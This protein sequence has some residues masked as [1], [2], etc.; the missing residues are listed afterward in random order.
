MV[1]VELF[2]GLTVGLGICVWQHYRWRK[3][4]KDLINSFSSQD[5]RSISLPPIYLVR[6][7]IEHLEQERK[8]VTQ[9]R[10]IWQRLIDRAPIG[11]L[12]VDEENQLL[13][14]NQQARI[15]L[16]LDRWRWG[17]VRLL[18]E[19]VR[20]Y[21]LDRLI[22]RTRKSQ[23][24]QE[25]EWIFY[26]TRHASAREPN[27]ASS[28][29]A[30]ASLKTVNAIALCGHSF[31]LPDRQV[32]VFLI[33]RQPIVD[34][35]HSRDRAIS[36]LA[37]E[38]KTPL[39]SISLVAENLLNR[40]QNPERGWVEQML[41]ETN[42]LITLVKEWLDLTQLEADPTKVL[43]YEEILLQEL[44]SS[45][46][47]TL[48]PIA[49]KKKVTLTL[50]S[51]E[52]LAIEG[53]R[54]RLIQ[55]FLNLLDNAIKHTPVAGEIVVNFNC[56][57]DP[58]KTIMMAEI[59][60]ID[61]GTGFVASDLPYV[62]NRLYRGEHSRTRIDNESGGSGLGL[63]IVQQIVQAHEGLIEAKNHPNLGGAWLRIKLPIAR[64]KKIA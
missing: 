38:L 50:M 5:D 21:E 28:E 56:D 6:R 1:N 39:T 26:F 63:A 32:G 53:D 13:W 31:P 14:C 8:K 46:W 47:Q 54:S 15:L 12:L 11:Y 3:R 52:S 34:L 16:K 29:T 45:V 49:K 25:K 48:E 44:I 17:E 64:I 4:L 43:K 57:R 37:H 7:E 41:K 30:A 2:I 55:V 23:Q 19:L 36:D 27:L 35:S 24:P 62:F 10:D 20:S 60:I 61:S 42:R 40:L 33:N 18:L 51:N 22:E 59:D 58:K 9:E